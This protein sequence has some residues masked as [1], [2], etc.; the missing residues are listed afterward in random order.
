MRRHGLERR[1]RLC[2]V[3]PATIHADAAATATGDLTPVRWNRGWMKRR[4]W[5]AGPP[6]HR[7]RSTAPSAVPWS[8]RS[9]IRRLMRLKDNVFYTLSSVFPGQCGCAPGAMLCICPGVSGH[10]VWTRQNKSNS[11]AYGGKIAQIKRD[12]A[13]FWIFLL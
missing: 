2:A 12:V 6:L 5:P 13:L 1:G 10:R 8:V 4:A 7:G 9:A 11:C 3:L